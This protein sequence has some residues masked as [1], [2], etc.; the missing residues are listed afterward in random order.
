MG[1][2]YKSH[3]NCSP[4]AENTITGVTLMPQLMYLNILVE[5]IEMIGLD[6]TREIVFTPTILEY[7]CQLAPEE[8][9][10]LKAITRFL[11]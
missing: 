5:M 7:C 6:V 3:G 2:T 8:G 10:Y 4:V 9:N 11:L 1:G